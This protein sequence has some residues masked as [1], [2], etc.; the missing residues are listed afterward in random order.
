MTAAVKHISVCICTFRRPDLLARLLERLRDQRSD[1]AFTYSLVVVDNDRTES[2]RPVVEGFSASSV[3]PVRYCV[4]PEQNIALARNKALENARGDF[5]A[6]IDDDEVPERDWLF[7]LFTT[8]N[9]YHADGVLGP[10]RPYFEHRPPDWVMKGAFFS[11]PDHATG[12]KLGWTETRS[13]N[14]LFNGEMVRDPANRFRA[15]FGTGSEDTDF[16]RRMTQQGRV[17]VWCN[18]APVHELVSP[19]RCTRSYL[20]KRA[21]LIGNNSF[22]HRTHRLKNLATSAVA[23]PLYALALPV[24]ALTGEH[25]FLRYLMKLSYHASRVLAFLGW[26]PAQGKA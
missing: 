14:V 11:R 6:C 15:E 12:R 22:K 26:S 8:A 21:I 25:R 3:V 23:V 7:Q 18:E 1:G 4:E 20:L 5:I 16:F 9:R 13:G 24:L 2:A 17:F 10:V 19:S